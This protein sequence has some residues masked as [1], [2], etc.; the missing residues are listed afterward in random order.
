MAAKI[1]TRVSDGMTL[2]HAFEKS[3]HELKQIQGLAGAIAIDH[4]GNIYHQ[5]SHPTMVY[6]S[7]DGILLDI[8]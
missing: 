6:A 1:V 7:Y 8:F 2:V 5:E 4:K 3:F